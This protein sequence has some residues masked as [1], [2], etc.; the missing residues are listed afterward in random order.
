[1]NPKSLP[2]FV[3][4]G[5]LPGLARGLRTDI[6]AGLSADETCLDGKVTFEEAVNYQ[7]K[8]RDV[9][10][11]SSPRQ[12]VV[13]GS[14]SGPFSDRLRVYGQNRIPGKRATPLWKLMW[15]AYNDAV[16]LLLTAAAVISLALGLYETFGAEHEPGA[17]A[18]VDWVEGVAICVAIVIVVMV[19]SLNDW[20]K[21]RAFVKL[22]AKKDD[23][24]VKVVRS[25]RSFMA[26]VHD[27]LAGDVLH[28]EVRLLGPHN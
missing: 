14:S 3:A 12:A 9:E 10:N 25:G 21:E 2:A 28:L 13:R 20:Q 23:R 19:G 8:V 4:L 24:E 5:G 17:P 22:N 26:N 15:I 27:V 6:H 7:T 16:L 1:M 18:P 11:S